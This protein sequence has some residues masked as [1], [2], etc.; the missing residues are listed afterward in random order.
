MWDRSWKMGQ[1]VDATEEA[2]RT[3]MGGE[4]DWN[5]NGGRRW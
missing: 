4:G 3:S 2:E 5:G 1:E